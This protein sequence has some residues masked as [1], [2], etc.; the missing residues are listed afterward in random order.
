MILLLLLQFNLLYLKPI[1]PILPGLDSHVS[2]SMAESTRSTA[3]TVNKVVPLCMVVQGSSNV[4][5]FA[6]MIAFRKV[7]VRMSNEDFDIV[8]FAE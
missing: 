5:Q 6:N 7:D 8:I 1:Q 2:N 3:I 4:N